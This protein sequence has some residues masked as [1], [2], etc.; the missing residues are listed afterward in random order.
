MLGGATAA[1]YALNWDHKSS[2]LIF[3]VQ[4]LG[5]LSVARAAGP[6]SVT[7]AAGPAT[8]VCVSDWYETPMCLS[9]S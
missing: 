7:T 6:G 9:L 8:G 1:E 2:M 3:A 5:G 4:G